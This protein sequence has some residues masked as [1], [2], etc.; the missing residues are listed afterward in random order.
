MLRCPFWK[1]SKRIQ[2][3]A[4]VSAGVLQAIFTY[5]R[6]MILADKDYAR[7]AAEGCARVAFFA[8]DDPNR[9]SSLMQSAIEGNF[10][11]F[12]PVCRIPIQEPYAKNYQELF[13]ILLE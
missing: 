11:D 3:K 6:P 1:N 12:A 10:R 4:K 7:E 13:D 5:A 2:D 9:L 8:P